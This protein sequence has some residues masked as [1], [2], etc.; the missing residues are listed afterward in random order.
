MLVLLSAE[1]VQ[2]VKRFLNATRAFL[3]IRNF[4]IQSAID[5]EIKI[6]PA[7]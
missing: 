4:Q 6:A 3:Q 2:L 1:A 5:R 7:R